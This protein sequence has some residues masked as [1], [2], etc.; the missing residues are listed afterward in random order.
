M[1]A[2]SMLA[3]GCATTRTTSTEWTADEY[4][5]REGVVESVR[6]VVHRVEGNP[7]GGA[8]VGA[9]IGAVLFGGRGARLPAPRPARR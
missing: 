1:L 2:M 3:T 7:A 8:A 9:L 4:Q 6:Q 5:P